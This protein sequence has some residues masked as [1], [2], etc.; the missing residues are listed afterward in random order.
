MQLATENAVSIGTAIGLIVS[1]VW[2]HSRISELEERLQTM[3]TGFEE[4]KEVMKTVLP[5][6]DVASKAQ[7]DINRLRM[8]LSTVKSYRVSDDDT[9]DDDEEELIRQNISMLG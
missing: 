3:D 5:V 7:D 9:E 6:K 2:L 8:M 4:I 1:T